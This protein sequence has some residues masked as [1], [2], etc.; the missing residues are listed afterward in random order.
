MSDRFFAKKSKKARKLAANAADKDVNHSTN[1]ASKTR[2]K[3]AKRLR[4]EEEMSGRDRRSK[5]VE[6][7][8]LEQSSDDMD[9]MVDTDLEDEASDHH[10][11]SDEELEQRETE[12][13]KR[14]RLAK[15]YIERLKIDASKYRG[16]DMCDLNV[17]SYNR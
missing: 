17:N 11:N 1:G 13:E 14:L 15:Q 9:M 6:D 7:E 2:D 5:R 16:R 3:S 12:A 10:L 4:S 8:E